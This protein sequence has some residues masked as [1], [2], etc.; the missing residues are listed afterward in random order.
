LVEA[1]L[2]QSV[3]ISSSMKQIRPLIV[4]VSVTKLLVK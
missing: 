1:A 4:G 2:P 3:P